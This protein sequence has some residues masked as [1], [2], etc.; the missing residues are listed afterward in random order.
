[1]I[2]LI[3]MARLLRDRAGGVGDDP[4]DTPD[5]VRQAALDLAGAGLGEEAQRHR[6]EMRVERVAQVLHDVLADDVVDVGLADAD[7]GRS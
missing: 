6:L 4:L 3:V 7:A 2:V 5:V 1:M